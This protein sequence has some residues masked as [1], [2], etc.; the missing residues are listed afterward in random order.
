MLA[1][2]VE[3]DGGRRFGRRSPTSE[4]SRWPPPRA[5]CSLE[6]IV[7]S[8]KKHASRALEEASNIP[9]LHMIEAHFYREQL[10]HEAHVG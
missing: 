5:R 4:S 9:E 10:H 3:A 6:R 8:K 7:S 2:S 1:D